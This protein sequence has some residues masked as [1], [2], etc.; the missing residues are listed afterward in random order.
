MKRLEAAPSTGRFSGGCG[1]SSTPSF[2]RWLAGVSA[3]GHLSSLGL[4]W[5]YPFTAGTV[6]PRVFSASSCFRCSE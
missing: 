6:F 4:M 5:P 1:D 3:P 2:T